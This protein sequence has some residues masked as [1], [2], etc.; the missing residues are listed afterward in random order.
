VTV[1]R[2]NLITASE[3]PFFRSLNALGTEVVYDSG[4][5]PLLLDKALAPSPRDR[6]GR[7]RCWGYRGSVRSDG[8]LPDRPMPTI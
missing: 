3:M 8:L 6:I 1:R 2:R 5:Y 4:D 7:N